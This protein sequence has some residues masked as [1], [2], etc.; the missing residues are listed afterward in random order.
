MFPQPQQTRGGSWF[1][2]FC[3]IEERHGFAP[4]SLCGALTAKLNNTSWLTP[5]SDAEAIIE[6]GRMA[7]TDDISG[8]R[9]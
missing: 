1:Y 5:A 7:A 8:C 2:I 9:S 6:R 3:I 4:R